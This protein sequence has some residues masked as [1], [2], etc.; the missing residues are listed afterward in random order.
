MNKF[1]IFGNYSKS[2]S[3]P[4]KDLKSFKEKTTY[5]CGDYSFYS[6]TIRYYRY[7]FYCLSCLLLLV[8]LFT[9]SHEFAFSSVILDRMRFT[10][11]NFLG[12]W[13]MLL[14]FASMIVGF[15]LC[16]FREATTT[17]ADKFRHK[18]A[19]VYTRKR[20]KYG[21]N[22]LFV[23]TG[24]SQER[25][26]LK[27]EYHYVLAKIKEKKEEAFQLLKE[28]KASNLDLNAKELLINQALA[29]LTDSLE[30]CLSRYKNPV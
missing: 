21:I 28:I 29:E 13:A 8:S 22:H 12:L 27:Q 14:A 16:T 6:S 3:N 10:V 2:S 18:A 24:Q 7:G 15:S 30:V 17:L 23:F 4:S 26:A 9:L 5:D 19:R 11:R 25:L 20:L 1:S